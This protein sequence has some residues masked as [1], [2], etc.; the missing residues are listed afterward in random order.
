MT[1][2]PYIYLTSHNTYFSHKK[3]KNT[4]SDTIIRENKPTLEREFF[5]TFQS[6]VN[7]YSPFLELLHSI[8]DKLID[9]I[10]LL[11]LT[12]FD[13]NKKYKIYLNYFKKQKLLGKE[14]CFV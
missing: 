4:K 9:K 3:V 6:F 13:T 12:R 2:Y 1:L 8:N 11:S 10:R 5:K 14:F 7:Q